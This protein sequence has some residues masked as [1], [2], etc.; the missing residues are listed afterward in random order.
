MSVQ[1]KLRFGQAKD[2]KVIDEELINSELIAAG[3][4]LNYT[5]VKTL[6]LSD[7]SNLKKVYLQTLWKYRTSTG[8]TTW[9]S[10]NWTTTS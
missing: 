2:P 10:C 3:E 4:K 9:K 1:K 5:E 8:S 6:S 7:K